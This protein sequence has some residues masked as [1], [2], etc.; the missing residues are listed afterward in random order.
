MR[1][2][3][4][5]VEGAQP[6]PYV[7]LAPHRVVQNRKG[8][9]VQGASYQ[10]MRPN[11]YFHLTPGTSGLMLMHPQPGAGE[12]LR[13]LPNNKLTDVTQRVTINT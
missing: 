4:L 9:G 5:S 2:T 1:P 13:S 6:I 3:N 10:T 12:E 8:E 11:R 7:P